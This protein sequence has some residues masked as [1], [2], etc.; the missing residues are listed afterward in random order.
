MDGTS[1]LQ[2]NE[3]NRDPDKAYEITE[4]KHVSIEAICRPT[5]SIRLA[6]D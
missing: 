3:L 4:D 6:P 1:T 5:V 2:L